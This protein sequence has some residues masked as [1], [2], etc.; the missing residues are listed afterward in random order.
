MAELASEKTELRGKLKIYLGAVAGVGKTYAMLEEAHRRKSVGEDIAIGIVV[1]HGRAETA[2]LTEGLETVPMQKITYRDQVFEE[3]DVDAVLARRPKCVLVDE[4]AHTNIPG[5]RHPKRWQSALEIL[6]AGIDVLS[7]LNIQHLESLNDKIFD[8]TGINVRETLPD[9]VLE[10]ADEAV[11]VDVSSETL[12]SRL[13]NGKIYSQDKIQPALENFF[14]AEN[15]DGLRGI[16]FRIAAEDVY[17]KLQDAYRKKFA[18]LQPKDQTA[19]FIKPE[20]DYVKLI[21]KAYSFIKKIISD[22]W[23]VYIR[24]P[25]AVLNPEEKKNLE[26]FELMTRNFGG[27]FKIIE[28]ESVAEAIAGFID[29]NDITYAIIGQ[30]A[31]LNLESIFAGPLINRIIKKTGRADVVVVADFKGK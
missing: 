3:M 11:L 23:V 5:T 27:Y 9:S 14:R 24:Y 26:E 12:I 4:L 20:K 30:P 16:A 15:I 8:I 19:V 31:S 6:E 7:T 13:K 21:R 29:E 1:T 17:E 22:L 10:M 2:K 18:T 28:N 25:G